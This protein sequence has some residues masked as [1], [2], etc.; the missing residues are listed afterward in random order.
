MGRQHRNEGSKRH[1]LKM[2]RR[3]LEL[4]GPTCRLCGRHGRFY[5]TAEEQDTHR[6]GW[7]YL[8]LGHVVPYALGGPHELDNLQLEHNACN[9]RRKDLTLWEWAERYDGYHEHLS[10]WRTP[11]GAPAAPPG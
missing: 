7:D 3:L 6:I 10:A 2:R 5:M 4:F 9:A 11:P 1:R 8:T